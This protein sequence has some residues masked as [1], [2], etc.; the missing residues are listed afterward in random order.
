MAFLGAINSRHSDHSRIK[1]GR[2]IGWISDFIVNIHRGSRD[3]KH[4]QDLND[5]NEIRRSRKW[6]NLNKSTFIGLKMWLALRGS[7][8]NQLLLVTIL[9]C[10]TGGD[11]GK[12]GKGRGGG[13]QE[14]SYGGGRQ[15]SYGQSAVRSTLSTFPIEIN[16]LIKLTKI[17]R[18]RFKGADATQSSFARRQK[19]KQRSSATNGKQTNQEIHRNIEMIFWDGFPYRRATDDRLQLL[20]GPCL[21]LTAARR[22]QHRLSRCRDPTDH[23]LRWTTERPACRLT[24]P[25]QPL[26]PLTAVAEWP[27]RRCL[28]LIT[29][30]PP[31]HPLL[32]PPIKTKSEN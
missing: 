28:P 29:V 3:S 30:Q 23:R 32:L 8:S 17:K 22:R 5:Q 6:F 7:N 26:K 4:F 20:L 11:A 9:L 14:Q 24:S 13:M 12:S 21:H 15:Q 1:R 19:P 18:F 25:N 16:S 31:V 2:R 27:K 10:A